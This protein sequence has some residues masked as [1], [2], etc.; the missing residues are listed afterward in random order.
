[1]RGSRR[2]VRQTEDTTDHL[3]TL[4]IKKNCRAEKLMAADLPLKFHPVA[5]KLS[6]DMTS[7]ARLGA[8]CEL[9]GLADRTFW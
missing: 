5:I 3:P 6:A 1:M 8:T 7:F 2:D 9:V 4:S